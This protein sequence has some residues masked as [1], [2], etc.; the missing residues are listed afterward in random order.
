MEGN[1][2]S[3]G[4]SYGQISKLIPLKR[5]TV[6]TICRLYLKRNGTLRDPSKHFNKGR[7]K[8]DSA[9]MAWITDPKTLLSQVSKS[10]AARCEQIYR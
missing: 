9:Q 1:T 6:V 10:A 5:G 8:L 4:M 7:R 3:T 2:A